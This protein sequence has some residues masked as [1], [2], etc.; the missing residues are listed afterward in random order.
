LQSSRVANGSTSRISHS[1]HLVSLSPPLYEED[2]G[3]D[4]EE[5]VDDE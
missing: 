3:D 4:E 1:R 5:D 2:E